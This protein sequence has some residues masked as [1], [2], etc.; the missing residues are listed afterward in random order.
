MQSVDIQRD[1]CWVAA[2]CLEKTD[3]TAACFVEAAVIELARL[4]AGALW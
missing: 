3:H 1:D 4:R 2:L